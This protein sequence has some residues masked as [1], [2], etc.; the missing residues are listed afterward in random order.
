MTKRTKRRTKA[1]PAGCPFIRLVHVPNAL[2]ADGEPRVAL[3][4]PPSPGAVSRRPAL[5]MFASIAAALTHKRQ[6]ESAAVQKR[7]GRK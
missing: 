5:L 3:E 1:A 4:L 7:G 6:A 2:D